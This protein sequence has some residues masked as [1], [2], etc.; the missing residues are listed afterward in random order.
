MRLGIDPGI[1]G[2]IALISGNAVL[3][4]WDMPTYSYTVKAKVKDKATKRMVTKERE[5]REVDGYKLHQILFGI[6]ND[7]VKTGLEVVVEMQQHNIGA[8]RKGPGGEEEFRPDSPMTAFM[9]GK[10]YGKLLAILEVVF[11]AG[12]FTIVSP[13]GWKSRAGLQR[14]QK[15]DAL[16]YCVENFDTQNFISRQKDIGRAEAILIA[17]Y[18]L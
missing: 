7:T 2:A 17:K 16:T 13:A 3:N 4:C 5:R 9:I 8:T 1:T 15:K 6:K 14:K 10:N 18:G 12:N 11:S